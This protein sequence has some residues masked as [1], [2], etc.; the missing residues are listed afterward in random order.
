MTW[1][2]K[3]AGSRS[4][5]VVASLNFISQF[6]FFS[7]FFWGKNSLSLFTHSSAAPSR[8]LPGRIQLTLEENV[9]SWESADS[10]SVV[11][12]RRQKPG[13]WVYVVGGWSYGE[14]MRVREDEGGDGGDL[15]VERF[16]HW[17]NTE[18]EGK[19]PTTMFFFVELLCA[20]SLKLLNISFLSSLDVESFC[21]FMIRVS[22]FIQT[23]KHAKDI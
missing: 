4:R 17:D 7:F 8:L 20:L 19:M 3:Q 23:C 11:F 22:V 16:K 1:E 18:Q 12:W 6:S 5:A 14:W 2:A 21:F 10:S 13:V 9:E 15:R